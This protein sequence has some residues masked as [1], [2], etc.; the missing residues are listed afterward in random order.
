M[1]YAAEKGILYQREPRN[2][3]R[4]YKRP[5]NKL[6]F[7]LRLPQD[8]HSNVGRNRSV[9]VSTAK[10]LESWVPLAQANHERAR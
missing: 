7:T 3:A 4:G 1:E 6:Q 8:R 9:L 10:D 2:L 5:V